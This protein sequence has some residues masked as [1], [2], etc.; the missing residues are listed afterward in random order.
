[1]AGEVVVRD[2]DCLSGRERTTRHEAWY[3]D[4]TRTRPRLVCLHTSNLTKIAS[5]YRAATPGNSV[6]ITPAGTLPHCEGISEACW[7]E[8]TRTSHGAWYGAETRP[9]MNDDQEDRS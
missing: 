7:L 5:H 2:P 8:G 9:P 6:P 1:M 4:S 3:P